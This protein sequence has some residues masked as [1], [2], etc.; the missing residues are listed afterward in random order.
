MSGPTRAQGE[1]GAVPA[2]AFLERVRS[3]LVASSL[4]GAAAFAAA[5]NEALRWSAAVAVVYLGWDV[6]VYGFLGILVFAALV[7]GAL[8]RWTPVA[9]AAHADARLGLHDR[10]ASL[11]DFGGRPEI[12]EPIREAQA[13]ETALA[14]AGATPAV[15]VPIA[16]W[17]KAGPALLAV[18]MLYQFFIP[19]R[20]SRFSPMVSVIVPVWRLA[21]TEGGAPGEAGPADRGDA[22]GTAAADKAAEGPATAK[23]PA[24][25]EEPR[26]QGPA[27][28]K[29]DDRPGAKDTDAGTKLA[30][31]SATRRGERGRPGA[32]DGEG[33]PREPERI[34]SERVGTRLAKVVDPLYRAGGEAAPAAVLP[35]GV[36]TFHLLPQAGGAG[37]GG[38]GGEGVDPTPVRVDLDAVPAPY[39]PIVKAYFDQLARASAPAGAAPEP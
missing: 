27:T 13:R 6:P 4:L 16:R 38:A 33:D 10:L 3:R 37:A 24:E 1:T 23:P 22:G 36:T 12:P 34:E 11:V 7:P 5:A 15:A 26:A 19:M 35:A 17:R 30:D 25:G 18:C 8:R 20:A 32:V 39:R 2:G 31:G 9:A 28:A 14:L 29:T 21:P